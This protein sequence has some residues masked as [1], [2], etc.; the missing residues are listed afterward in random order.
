VLFGH[1][2]EPMGEMLGEVGGDEEGG[3]N[4]EAIKQFKQAIKA[5]D[6]NLELG[7]RIQV[8]AVFYGYVK[9]FYIEA[10]QNARGATGTG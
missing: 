7:L 8:M 9:F 1:V 5:L 4:F 3:G 6:G 10:E 2:F